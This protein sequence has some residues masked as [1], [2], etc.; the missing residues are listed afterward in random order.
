VHPEQID[1]SRWALSRIELAVR[2]DVPGVDPDEFRRLA[3]QAKITC[4]VSRP[5]GGTEIV[6]AAVELAG[7]AGEGG[8]VSS[9][10]R[11]DTLERTRDGGA[12]E[13]VTAFALGEE[14]EDLGL[15]VNEITE[16]AGR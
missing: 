5:L 1:A 12:I 10:V 14:S 8:V 15:F 16:L 11:A 2:G 13:Q 3:E 7:A 6:L 9:H 4:P